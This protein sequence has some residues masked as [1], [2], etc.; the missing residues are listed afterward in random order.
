M[1]TKTITWK[2]EKWKTISNRQTI[3][4]EGKQKNSNEKKGNVP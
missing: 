1:K 2:R 3:S 4:G